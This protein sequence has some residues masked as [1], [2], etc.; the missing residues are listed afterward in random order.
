MI[1]WVPRSRGDNGWRD[2]APGRYQGRAVLGEHAGEPAVTVPV[3]VPDW[4]RIAMRRVGQRLVQLARM[5]FFAFMLVAWSIKAAA[6]GLRSAWPVVV[7]LAVVLLVAVYRLVRLRRWHA[8]RRADLLLTRDG[9]AVDDLFVPWYQVERVVRF[10][11]EAPFDRKGNRNFIA[12][13]IRDFVAVTGL[14]PFEAGLANLTRRRLV[15]L[16]ET[17][18][19]SHPEE[20]AAALDRIVADPEARHL[21]GSADG[22]RLVDEGPARVLPRSP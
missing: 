15:V 7:V 12:L 14:S 5:A 18:E 17:A 22:T 2:V 8:G 3:V 9:I 11:F 16:G 13:Q 20:L 21:L 10:H 1:E 19:L 6:G 4:A